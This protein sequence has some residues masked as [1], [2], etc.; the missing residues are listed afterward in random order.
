MARGVEAGIYRGQQEVF[1]FYQQFFDLFERISL[2]PD[3]LIEAGDSVVVPNS[4][5]V[6]RRKSPDASCSSVGNGPS[7]TRV[8]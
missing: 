8:V 1:R 6:L 4:A 3:R 7:P 2:E 5:P